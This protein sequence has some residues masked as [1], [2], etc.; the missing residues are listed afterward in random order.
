M[1]AKDK[2][3]QRRKPSTASSQATV[4]ALLDAAERVLAR[5]GFEAMTTARIA[6]EAGVGKATV[7]HYFASK[8]ALAQQIGL[9]MW[10]KL[11]SVVAARFAEVVGSGFLL[12]IAAV[13]DAALDHVAANRAL[14]GQ[15]F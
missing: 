4:D 3:R 8:D 9:R 10:R 5:D 7:Y 2:T 14:L 15:W 6:A 13:V 12:T 11:A 1:P